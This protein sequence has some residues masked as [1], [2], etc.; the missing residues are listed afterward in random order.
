VAGLQ[1]IPGVGEKKALGLFEAA[2]GWVAEQAAAQAAREAAEEAEPGAA[3]EV[4]DAPGGDEVSGEESPPS[5]QQ[6]PAE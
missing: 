4:A 3:A 1:E 5:A 2:Q 6:A